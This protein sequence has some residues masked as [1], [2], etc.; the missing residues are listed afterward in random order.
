MRTYLCV[1]HN[2]RD[3]KIY[4]QQSLLDFMNMYSATLAINKPFPPLDSSQ[5]LAEQNTFVTYILSWQQK[6]RLLD[7]SADCCEVD[8]LDCSEQ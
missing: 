2:Y 4:K 5:Y 7:S 1:L 8:M 3:T 6:Q